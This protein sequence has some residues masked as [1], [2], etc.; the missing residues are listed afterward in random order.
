MPTTSGIGTTGGVL[1]ADALTVGLAVG[2]RFGDAVRELAGD[3]V[4]ELAGDAVRELAAGAGA[5]AGVGATAEL[6]RG[7]C[8]AAAGVFAAAA[9]LAGAGAAV[10]LCSAR[11]EGF[12]EA[13]SCHAVSDP[14]SSRSATPPTARMTRSGRRGRRAVVRAA[15]G[16]VTEAAAGSSVA[17]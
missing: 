14:A 13:L 17:V 1:A 10:V 4:R 9:W 5:D 15:V 8:A 2:V 11:T 6:D 16:C 3:A 12:G 7:V